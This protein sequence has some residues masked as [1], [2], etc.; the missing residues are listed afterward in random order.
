MHITKRYSGINKQAQIVYG[1][2]THANQP[3]TYAMDISNNMD[4]IRE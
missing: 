1:N 3:Y 2:E 4:A